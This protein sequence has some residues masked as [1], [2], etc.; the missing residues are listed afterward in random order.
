MKEKWTH[1][2]HGSCNKWFIVDCNKTEKN[3][4]T[5]QKS[6]HSQ[7]INSTSATKHPWKVGRYIHH[8]KVCCVMF[9]LSV[10]VHWHAFSPLSHSFFSLPRPSSLLPLLQLPSFPTTRTFLHSLY[11]LTT[12]L[13]YF[14]HLIF[15]QVFISLDCTPESS[16]RCQEP[17][18]VCSFLLPSF[19]C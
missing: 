4:A 15:L 14:L 2:D 5:V 8:N 9:S 6:H 18:E 1:T 12:F 17:V 11:I 16:W 13:A 7:T 19:I 3:T 10:S